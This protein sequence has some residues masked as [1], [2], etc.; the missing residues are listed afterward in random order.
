MKT[1]PYL[2]PG[3]K[4]AIDNAKGQNADI[5]MMVDGFITDREALI[6]RDALWYA[7]SNGIVVHFIASD[8]QI[9]LAR[10]QIDQVVNIKK[11]NC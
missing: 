5:V 7:R 4:M 1:L 9:K 3:M 2:E 6:L 10:K 11:A 8:E